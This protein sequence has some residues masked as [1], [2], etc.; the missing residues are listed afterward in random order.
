[1]IA[2]TDATVRLDVAPIQRAEIREL[3]RRYGVRARFGFFTR[4]WWALDGDRL[5]TAATPD[6]LGEA[7]MLA[8]WSDGRGASP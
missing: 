7:V 4:E 1:M 2:V 5:V 8:R 3:E 6:R